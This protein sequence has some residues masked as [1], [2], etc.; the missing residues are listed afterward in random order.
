MDPWTTFFL[1]R[2]DRFLEVSVHHLSTCSPLDEVTR[3]GLG[4]MDERMEGW[5][6]GG[7]GDKGDV[8]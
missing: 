4:V 5:R 6:D 3:D 7:R 8:G 2:L 1:P